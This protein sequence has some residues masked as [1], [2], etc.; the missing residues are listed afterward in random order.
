MEVLYFIDRLVTSTIQKL[1]SKRIARLDINTKFL[2]VLIIG[3]TINFAVDIFTLSKNPSAVWVVIALCAYMFLVLAVALILKYLQM[4]LDPEI[5]YSNDRL[6]TRGHLA[7]GLVF[8]AVIVLLIAFKFDG[9]VYFRIVGVFAIL[10]A[11]D[12]FLTRK[13]NNTNKH[14]FSISE[15]LTKLIEKCRTW[16]PV[17]TQ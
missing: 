7:W 3:S 14:K 15:A 2:L 11:I 12:V 17:P 8:T 13:K 16:L 9:P 6:Y 10:E 1:I 4:F 5:Y